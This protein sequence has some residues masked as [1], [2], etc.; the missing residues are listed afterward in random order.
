MEESAT[1]RLLRAANCGDYALAQEALADGAD[2]NALSTTGESPLVLA[3]KRARKDEISSINGAKIARDILQC[4]ALDL[5][6]T[7]SARHQAGLAM[8]AAIE[9]GHAGLIS[10]L[11]ACGA[12]LTPIHRE[13]APYLVY[14]AFLGRD[15]PVI[16]ALLDA[17][18]DVNT[19]D[20]QG[21]TA[22][23]AAAYTSQADTIRY[24]LSRGADLHTRDAEGN[25]AL[26]HAARTT[27]PYKL[28]VEIL[29]ETSWRDLSTRNDAGHTPHHLAQ[30]PAVAEVI[31]IK[32]AFL[33]R[34][35]VT[36]TVRRSFRHR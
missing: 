27:A 12:T 33:R 5:T 26:H 34:Q 4:P 3:L 19:R 21:M 36:S 2:V 31:H 16:K 13:D 18:A 17:G 11:V 29:L 9:G 30:D 32:Q 14:A 20:A 23:M 7:H 1:N 35:T 24:L 6:S 28:C 10:M 8:E 15:I 25:T 22:L